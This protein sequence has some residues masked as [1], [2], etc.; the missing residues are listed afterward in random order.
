MR[1]RGPPRHDTACCGQNGREGTVAPGGALA[2][3]LPVIGR[4]A[5]A[6]AEIQVRIAPRFAR[7][8]VRERVGGYLRG[9][10]D[11]VERKNGWQLAEAIGETGPQGVQRLLN[12]AVWDA[13]GV[14]DDLRG[15]VVDALGDRASGVLIV[16]E[17]GFL[18]KGTHSCGGARQ[19]TGTAG[20]PSN[21]QVGVFLTYAAEKGAAF[22]DRALYL[23][24][25]WTRD[26]QRRAKAGIPKGTRFA[27]KLTLAQ[28]MRARAFAA[29]V[30]ARW[31][32]ADSGYGR[33]HACRQ[34]LEQR[35][36]AYAIMIPKTTAVQYQGRRERAEQLS[37]RLPE[38]AWIT[39][40]TCADGQVTPAHQWVCL[41]L[42]EPCAKGRCRWLLIRRSLE[43]PSDLAYYL[44]YSPEETSRQELVRVCDRRWAIEEDFAEA[45][46]EVGLD[47]LDQYEVRTWTAWHR[48]I[49][50]CLLAHAALVV[51]RARAMSQEASAHEATTPKG[52][53]R[54]AASR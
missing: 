49:T 32:T 46:G 40:P 43:E 2:H 26:P 22:I 51:Q 37:E 31:V 47:Q 48:F 5:E 25:S 23:P 27:T 4:W 18:K 7:A 11:R 8:E 39:V 41:L 35:D 45:K 16:D 12:A 19:Y 29:R 10:L 24:R 17:T 14:R 38:D 6:L 34:W 21:A 50:L 3:E 1:P 36:Q 9:L 30:P 54:R 13:E 28:R 15:Y 20:T 33:S 44:A 42:S 53:P 52:G